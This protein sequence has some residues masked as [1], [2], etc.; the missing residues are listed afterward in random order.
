MT[1][2]ADRQAFWIHSRY[3]NTLG[4]RPGWLGTSMFASTNTS[5]THRWVLLCRESP[6]HRPFRAA[7][8]RTSAS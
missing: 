3:P 4:R 1:P 5:A 8:S 2:D 6:Y 7:A